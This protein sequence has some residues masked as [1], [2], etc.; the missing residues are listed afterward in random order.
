MKTVGER[1]RQ[2]REAKGWSG[3]KLALRVGYK[4]QSGISNLEARATGSGGNKIGAIAQ[5]L[6]VSLDWLMNG[7]DSENVPFLAPS[8]LQHLDAAY[9]TTVKE[10]ELSLYKLPEARQDRVTEDLL[11]LWSQLDAEGKAHALSLLQGFV[12]GR[13]PHADGSA[14]AMAG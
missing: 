5:A 7:P 9:T 8:L 13:R 6:S 2:A 12:A 11:R 1:I 14:S 3:E 4:T 10:P